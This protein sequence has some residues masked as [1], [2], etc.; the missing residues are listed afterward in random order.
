MK[1]VLLFSALLLVASAV[2][3]AA[4]VKAVSTETIG[5]S[6]GVDVPSKWKFES[7]PMPLEGYTNFR[8]YADELKVGI[9]GFPL[10]E[11]A[12][13]IPALDNSGDSVK[14]A[15]GQYLPNAV[16]TEIAPLSFDN[17]EVRGSYATLSAKKNGNG[18]VVFPTITRPSL[19]YQCVTTSIV[20]A[21][22]MWFAISIA[23][24]N[25]SSENH[26]AAILMLATI[27]QNSG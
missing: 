5:N 16:E 25:C 15:M 12:P 24:N 18:F 19:I 22:R 4:G 1:F 13:A 23:S 11:N 9:T 2:D 8:I 26:Q 21:K 3:S 27:K 14:E 10:P 20:R 7:W 6:I 17:G